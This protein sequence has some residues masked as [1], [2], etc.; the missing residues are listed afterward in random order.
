M[1]TVENLT[2]EISKIESSPEYLRVTD[3]MD[4]I[5]NALEANNRASKK[6]EQ[7]GRKGILAEL[8]KERDGLLAKRE[9][10]REQRD[11]G[12]IKLKAER[13]R[14]RSVGSD[15]KVVDDGS[16]EESL[17][18]ELAKIHDDEKRLLARRR[19]IYGVLEQ[20]NVLKE[21]EDF[22]KTLPDNKRRALEQVIGTGVVR[23]AT[24]VKDL[25]SKQS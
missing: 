17:R 25:G 19:Q 24:S 2:A 7:D 1:N 16:P 22:L 21:Q 10:L 14:A 18:A 3:Q 23:T 4:E 5:T 9:S 15:V 20:R 8:I 11:A 12:R 13:K 6:A